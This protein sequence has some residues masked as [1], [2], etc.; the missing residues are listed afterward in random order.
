MKAKDTEA[1]RKELAKMMS[2]SALKE[3]DDEDGTER[4]KEQFVLPLHTTR[5]RENL[6]NVSY[7][8]EM[9]H[10]DDLAMPYTY[11]KM[12]GD[13]DLNDEMLNFQDMCCYNLF[14]KKQRKCRKYKEWRK[15][16]LLEDDRNQMEFLERQIQRMRKKEENVVQKKAVVRRQ[17]LKQSENDPAV[18]NANTAE[19]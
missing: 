1:K 14:R 11:P 19:A 17:D 4:E 2:M 7:L 9:D 16:Q 5:R 12:E 18:A 13:L 10:F 3:N 15:D 8:D 6:L